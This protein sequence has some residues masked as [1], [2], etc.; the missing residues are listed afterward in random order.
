MGSW[1]LT[2]EGGQGHFARQ[3]DL[4]PPGTAAGF[5]S[6]GLYILSAAW[7]AE[8]RFS[9][10]L[11]SCLVGSQQGS[12]ARA[13]TWS[14]EPSWTL[15]P[16]PQRCT[17][18]DRPCVCI[19]VLIRATVSDPRWSIESSKLPDCPAHGIRGGRVQDVV[20]GAVHGWKG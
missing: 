13:E 14:S 12:G 5:F 7:G 20:P 3:G 1:T 17:M 6:P 15:S 10:A 16:A 19:H 11:G 9:W 8:Q 4:A 2:L 18:N